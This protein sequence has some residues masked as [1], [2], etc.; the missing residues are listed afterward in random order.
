MSVASDQQFVVKA[1]RRIEAAGATV[2]QLDDLRLDDL[3]TIDWVPPVHLGY[4]A[5]ALERVALGEVEYL[6]IRAPN[7]E[8]VAIGG[9][10]FVV[11]RGAG[12]LWQV[13][14]HPG[15]RGLGLG[16]RLVTEAEARI[17]RRSCRYAVLGVEDGNP[18]AQV[19]YERLGY[20][21]IGREHD[22]WLQDGPGGQPELYETEITILGKDLNAQRG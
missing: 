16:T 12:I 20:V 5:D 7:G 11:R 9:V 13:V 19:L 4:V 6:A 14:T 10:D 21:P 18:R 1:R 8:P 15:L 17:E 3:G 2:L 22:S